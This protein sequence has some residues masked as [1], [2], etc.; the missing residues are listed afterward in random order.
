MGTARSRYSPCFPITGT[1]ARCGYGSGPH[2]DA[3][4]VVGRGYDEVTLKTTEFG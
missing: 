2:E 3:P 4:E 1:Q